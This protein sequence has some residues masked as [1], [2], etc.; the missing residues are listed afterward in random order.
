[1]K[2]LRIVIL[3]FGTARQKLVLEWWTNP[4]P[5]GTKLDSGTIYNRA[6]GFWICPSFRDHFLSRRAEP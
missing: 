5:L 2:K 3:R 1:M 6:E 4:K